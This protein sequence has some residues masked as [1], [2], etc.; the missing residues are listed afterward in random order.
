MA[1]DETSKLR[2]MVDA[3]VLFAGT[4]WPRFPYEVLQHAVR[5]DYQ[6]V[7]SP[8]VV[9]EARTALADYAKG[10]V[11]R[12]PDLLEASQ[13]EEVPTPAAEEITAN[14]GLV[15]DAKDVH[16]ALA[17]IN[18]GVDCLVSSDKDLTDPG[19]PVHQRLR[20]L[21][22]GTFLREHMGWTSEELEAI[23]DRTWD[24]L[25]DD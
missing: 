8:R 1:R 9:A 13:Y 2:V 11:W 22:P 15:R 12:F 7:L 23:R 21:L 6:L 20:V 14:A 5:A 25:A 24:D 19:E 4:L 10:T 3:N 18:A 17:A 16:V